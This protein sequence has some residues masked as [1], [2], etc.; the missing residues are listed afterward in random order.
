MSNLERI[1]HKI[2][3]MQDGLDK[4]KEDY[5]KDTQEFKKE[6]HN[7]KL[8]CECRITKIESANSGF[9]SFVKNVIHIVIALLTVLIINNFIGKDGK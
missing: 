5:Y 2:D 3:K 4:F 8:S 7:H 1:E 9:R 6:Y